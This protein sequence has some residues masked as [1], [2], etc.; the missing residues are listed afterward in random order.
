MTIKGNASVIKIILHI[1][2]SG[3]GI[4][5]A[6]NVSP[7]DKHILRAFKQLKKSRVLVLENGLYTLNYKEFPD[8]YKEFPDLKAGIDTY[9]KDAKIDIAGQTIEYG[10][11]ERKEISVLISEKKPKEIFPNKLLNNVNKKRSEI[12]KLME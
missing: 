3:E 4:K 2:T 9:K 11:T 8:L 10:A 12:I 5:S 6:Y 7:D 1:A